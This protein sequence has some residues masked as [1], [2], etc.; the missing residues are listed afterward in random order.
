MNSSLYLVTGHAGTA[1]RRTGLWLLMG[2]IA[3]LFFLF[4]AA[5]VMRMGLP[6]WRPLPFVPWQLW[7]S[8]ALLALASVAWQRAWRAADGGRAA[9]S[10]RAYG[11]ACLC[12]LAFL[13][14]Q[15]WAW[16]AMMA[17]NFALDGNPA[18][19]FFYL[20][21]GLHGLHVI[22]GLVVA[23]WAAGKVATI[24]LCARY[25]HFLLGLWLLMFALLFWL[26]PELVQQICGGAP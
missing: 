12:S 10:W 23:T 7:L 15:L 3:M 9:V 13:A 6:D 20:I 4:S 22:G 19:S 16:R 11:M 24:Q 18:N 2:V 26:T 14:S 8:T 1:A 21:T 25:W 17:A 5:Y